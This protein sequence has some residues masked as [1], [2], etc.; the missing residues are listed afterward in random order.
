M[1]AVTLTVW[2]PGTSLPALLIRSKNLEGIKNHSKKGRNLKFPLPS[3]LQMMRMSKKLSPSWPMSNISTFYSPISW[4]VT[5]TTKNSKRIAKKIT[6][7]TKS[8]QT[9]SSHSWAWRINLRGER[10][11]GLHISGPLMRAKRLVRLWEKIEALYL[12]RKVHLI[13]STKLISMVKTIAVKS[14]S[15]MLKEG[16]IKEMTFW[17]SHYACTMKTPWLSRVALNSRFMRDWNS[18]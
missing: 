2:F 8:T 7:W 9:R 17:I 5:S 15:S 10:P 18:H 1:R 14:L 4:T 13:V 11:R 3:L 12:D 6:S 16:T